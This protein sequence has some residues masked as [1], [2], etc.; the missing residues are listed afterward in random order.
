MTPE[1]TVYVGLE[2]FIFGEVGLDTEGDR[3]FEELA[4]EFDQARVELEA[5]ESGAFEIEGISR[6]LHGDS[7]AA[8]GEATTFDVF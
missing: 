8:L 1:D 3:E 4:V 6:E 5:F 7:G 2:D